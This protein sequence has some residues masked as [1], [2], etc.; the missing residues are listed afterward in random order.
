MHQSERIL[1]VQS[2]KIAYYLHPLKTA[3]K[4]EEGE[5]DKNVK[6]LP[7]EIQLIVQKKFTIVI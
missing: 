2:G 7:L 4:N 1:G 6:E 3:I 5:S